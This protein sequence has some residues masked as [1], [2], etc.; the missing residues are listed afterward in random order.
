M[1]DKARYFLDLIERTALALATEL[2]HTYT[3]VDVT[4]SVEAT[5]HRRCCLATERTHLAE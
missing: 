2:R 1:T 4:V 3:D 5:G